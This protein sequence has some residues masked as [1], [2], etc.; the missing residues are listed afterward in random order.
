M[1]NSNVN[2]TILTDRI[3]RESERLLITSISRSQAFQLERLNRFPKRIKLGNRSVGWRFSE[4]MLW[5]QAG[6]SLSTQG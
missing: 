6:G 4:L 1:S 2:Q 5:V 3:I